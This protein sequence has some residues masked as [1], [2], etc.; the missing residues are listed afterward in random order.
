[1][2]FSLAA[3]CA[4]SGQFGLVVTSS[5][6][7]V[8]A[9]CC[10]V[11][12]GAGA[13]A[14]QNVTD[15]GLGVLGLEMLAAGY[16]ARG[17]RDALVAV[18][19]YPEH[20]QLT[21]VDR[22]GNT[23]HHSGSRTLGRHATA[24]GYDCVAAGNLLRDAAVPVAMVAA[25]ES[26]AGQPLVERLLLAVEGGLAAGG[27]EGDVRTGGL[28]VAD[29]HPWPI[30]DLRVDWHEQPIAELRR[31]WDVYRPQMADYV[32]RALD[33]TRAPSYGVPGDL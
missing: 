27:E 15:P 21:V 13:V 7:C 10:W 20:R 11:R 17:V 2:T 31:V 9:R 18:G 19:D 4:T 28:K 30:C 22:D 26:A 16:T 14:S 32:T 24:Q 12:A 5:S 6:P 1:M 29:R 3:R 33:P 23:A 8:A 25:F